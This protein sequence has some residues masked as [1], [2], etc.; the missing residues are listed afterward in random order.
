MATHSMC[1]PG[2]PG[3]SE[4]LS[5]LGFAL[6]GGHPQHRVE[7]ILLARALR[8]AAALCGQQPHRLGVQVGHLAEVRVGLDGEVHIAVELVGGAG[9]PEAFDERDDARYRLHRADVVL[10][11]KHAQ[12]GHVL[13]EE[14]RLAFGELG[15]VLTVAHGPLQQRIVHVGHILDIVNLPLG[16]EPHALNEVERVVGRRMTH[17]GRV[18]R[19]DA[20]DVDAG[21][22][23][24][25]KGDP[26]A[27]RG[28]VDP[29]VAA[30]ARQGGDL[31]SGPGMHVMS[32]TGRCFRIR[33]G[34]G[35]LAG[36]AVLRVPGVLCPRRP[37]PDRGTAPDP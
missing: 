20:A 25:V 35:I 9:V 16:V 24:G 19:R 23:T 2:R 5:Q 8:V 34:Y 4:A 37:F 21:D 14:G 31:R 30:L 29:K 12:G 36:E 15:P 6:A 3:P 22:G 28:V 13:A 7:R 1:Q 11:R 26:S 17:M 33:T 10:R 18:V 32:V 27:G